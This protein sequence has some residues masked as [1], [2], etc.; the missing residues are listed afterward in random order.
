MNKAV[1]MV[2]AGFAVAFGAGL[3]LGLAGPKH[4]VGLAAPQ[5]PTENKHRRWWIAAQLDLS[6]LQEDQVRRI[7]EDVRKDMSRERDERRNTIRKERDDAILSMLPHEKH[8]AYEDIKHD[9]SSKMGQVDREPPKAI[10]KAIEQTKLVLSEPQRIKY[11]EMLKSRER[12]KRFYGPGRRT[13]ERATTRPA[14]I[15]P[16]H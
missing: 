9:Y 16:S 5:P 2:V 8:G 13:D 12:D 4:V 1:V 14:L 6:P 10:Q 7:W 3:V 11:D 15:Q